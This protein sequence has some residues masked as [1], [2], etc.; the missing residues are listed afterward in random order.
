VCTFDKD[1]PR[2]TAYD[3]H[4]WIYTKL[5][6]E[7]EDV[8]TIQVDGPKR[9]VFIKT[10]QAQTAEELIRRTNGAT[11]Y[12]HVTGEISRFSLCPAGLG[13]RSIRI[14]N[15]PPEMPADIIRNHL[16]KYGTVQSVTEEKWSNIYRYNV[17]NGIRIV[18]M[19]LKTHVPSTCTLKVIGP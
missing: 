1:S 13:R 6:L 15:L 16:T 10:I 7:S 14:A 11:T 3:I 8:A 5:R 4:E 12:E 18:T 17:G 19:D 9:S 2:I